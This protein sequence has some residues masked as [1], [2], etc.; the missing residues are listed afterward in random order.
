MFED[1]ISNVD[2]YSKYAKQIALLHNKYPPEKLIGSFFAIPENDYK[3]IESH[4]LDICVFHERMPVKETVRE[5][6]IQDVILIPVI[7]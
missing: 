4:L 5:I 2:I 3:A 6:R 1:E 7:K